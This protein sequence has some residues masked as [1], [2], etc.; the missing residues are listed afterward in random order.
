MENGLHLCSTLLHHNIV[1][2]IALDVFDVSLYGQRPLAYVAI[3]EP[4]SLLYWY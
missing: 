3:A 2:M 4:G 1:T